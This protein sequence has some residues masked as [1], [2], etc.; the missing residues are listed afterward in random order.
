[1]PMVAIV[2]EICPG[3]AHTFKYYKHDRSTEGFKKTSILCMCVFES[4]VNSSI[5]T[6]PP[7][8][9]EQVYVLTLATL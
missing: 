9:W 5:L 2:Q 7:K 6:S 4:C 1:M 3:D 8:I